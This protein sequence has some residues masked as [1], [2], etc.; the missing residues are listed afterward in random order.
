[1]PKQ[2]EKIVSITAYMPVAGQ[3][4]GGEGE[5]E[6]MQTV[7]GLITTAPDAI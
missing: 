7:S 1:M 4:G 5:E 3:Q 6:W 2:L